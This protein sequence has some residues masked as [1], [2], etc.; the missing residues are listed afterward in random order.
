MNDMCRHLTIRNANGEHATI[1][2]G[3]NLTTAW[4]PSTACK[5]CF[6]AKLA[7]QIKEIKGLRRA[8]VREI[9]AR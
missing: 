9:R 1:S 7:G 4:T 2:G 8:G 6:K 3:V 5:G